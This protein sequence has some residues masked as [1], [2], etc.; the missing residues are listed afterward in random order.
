MTV[1]HTFV[2]LEVSDSAYREVAGKL[3]AAGYDHAF[4]PQDEGEPAAIDMHGIA[5]VPERKDDEGKGD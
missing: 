5:L 2:K 3:A 1:T 4:I